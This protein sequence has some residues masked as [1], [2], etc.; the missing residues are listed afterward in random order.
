MGIQQ[1]IARRLPVYPAVGQLLRTVAD[2]TPREAAELQ[3]LWLGLMR[4]DVA[5][6]D[7]ARILQGPIREFLVGNWPGCGIPR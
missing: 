1:G 4:P 5:K 3:R 6:E 7:P 2:T